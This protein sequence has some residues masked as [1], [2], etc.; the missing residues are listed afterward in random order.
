M[1]HLTPL[2]ITGRDVLFFLIGAMLTLLLWLIP[3]KPKTDSLHTTRTAFLVAEMD[4][5]ALIFAYQDAVCS[6]RDN[7]EAVRQHLIEHLTAQSNTVQTLASTLGGSVGLW[8]Q[9]AQ[10]LMQTL[11]PSPTCVELGTFWE[12]VSDLVV[13]R[14]QVLEIVSQGLRP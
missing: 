4:T 2:S 12:A 5:G 10:A 14:A 9:S 11:T 8:T 13:A 7:A 6:E 1:S 3:A